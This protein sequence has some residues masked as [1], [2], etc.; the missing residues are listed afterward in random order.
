MF[1]SCSSSNVGSINID[2]FTIQQFL[3]SSD[4]PGEQ[5]APLASTS[6]EPAAQDQPDPTVTTSQDPPA[7]HSLDRPTQTGSDTPAC[8]ASAHPPPAKRRRAGAKA[9]KDNDGPLFVIDKIIAHKRDMV[10]V[11]WRGFPEDQAT[12]EPL[13]VI[14]ET[15]GAAIGAYFRTVRD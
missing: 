3:L 9:K 2:F 11:L 13:S 12:W 6:Q 4:T 15:A 5:T 10:K 8:D 1:R 7:P 14:A